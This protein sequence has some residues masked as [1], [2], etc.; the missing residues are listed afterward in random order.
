MKRISSLLEPLQA[1][2]RSPTMDLAY[3]VK[4]MSN[5]V[6]RANSMVSSA[7]R[8]VILLASEEDFLRRLEDGLSEAARRGVRVR[9]AVPEVEI[10]EELE[11]R[12]EIRS[13]VCSCLILVVDGQQILTVTRTPD[14]SGYAITS[15]DETLVRLGRDY[16]E[17]PRCCVVGI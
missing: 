10:S 6:A 8:E 5:V 11:K 7:R 17:S 14:G 3:V 15:T 1:G 16:W 13:I 4:G 2:S 9:L 12:A